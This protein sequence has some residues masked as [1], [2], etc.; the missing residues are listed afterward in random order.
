MSDFIVGLTGGV[1]AGKSEVTRRFEAL[2]IAV[3]DAD[4]AARAVV[5]PGQP[6][7]AQIAAR[8][9]AG[10]LQADGRLDRRALRERVF[11]DAGERQALEAITHPAIRTA[12]Q[13]G[14]RAAPGPYVIAAVPLLAEAGGRS[15]YPWVDRILVVDAP[16]SLQH[17]RLMRRDGVDEALASRMIAA[18]APRH[19][20][21][22]IADDVVLNDGL[23]GH[24]DAAV[25][26]LDAQYRALAAA[27]RQQGSSAG[28]DMSA[29]SERP[30]RN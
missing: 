17:A 18:Q 29:A 3:V 14:C 5:E 21:L 25:A 2:G 8:F 27:V 24:L 9:G 15:G 1:A 10:I 7:L 20:R 19:E 28:L 13:A 4:V 22:A 26:K 16:E 30:G 11:A 23:A 12:L 6:A